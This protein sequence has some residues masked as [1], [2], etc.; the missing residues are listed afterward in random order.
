MDLS[1][2]CGDA[3]SAIVLQALIGIATS[4][5]STRFSASLRDISQAIYGLYSKDSISR[6]LNKLN[7]RS[8]ILMS[9]SST[10]KTEITLVPEY[11]QEH[12]DLAIECLK[13][14]MDGRS[15]DFEAARKRFKME[16]DIRK[17]VPNDAN[18]LDLR[19]RKMASKKVKLS[20]IETKTVSDR[21]TSNNSN[22]IYIYN[23]TTVERGAMSSTA[24]QRVLRT[25]TDSPKN[26][27]DKRFQK[28]T[29]ALE[30]EYGDRIQALISQ[31]GEE[32]TI[33]GMRK[34]LT[35][36]Y[37]LE[38]GLPL[39]AFI[40]SP[41]KYVPEGSTP[42]RD[43][44]TPLPVTP[45]A[46]KVAKTPIVESVSDPAFTPSSAGVSPEALERA[47]RFRLN[48]AISILAQ[49]GSPRLAEVRGLDLEGLSN[50]G[51][52][53]ILSEALVAYLAETGRPWLET[54]KPLRVDL[55]V[56]PGL[57]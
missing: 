26:K 36:A 31:F 13:G 22:N 44:F 54:T 52:E 16:L 18:C 50:E 11:L 19:Q 17:T 37:W 8:L 41:E 24:I 28:S 12:R 5:G 20:Q 4:E 53:L 9:S 23:T 14:T 3:D 49:C 42:P 6:I 38:R 25:Y 2:V 1:I 30:R 7:E 35:D 15:Y 47:R 46:P 34:F 39:P 21:D 43:T 45:R 29:T 55:K 33:E 48:E 40:K 51:I 57:E 32:E 27:R 56:T 10:K